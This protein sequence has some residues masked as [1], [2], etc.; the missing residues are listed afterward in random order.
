MGLT[1]F[2]LARRRAEEAQAAEEA[3]EVVD[4]ESPELEESEA[5]NPDREALAKEALALG[6]EFKGKPAP[7]SVLKKWSFDRLAEAIKERRAFLAN[8]PQAEVEEPEG[9]PGEDGEGESDPVPEAG[10]QT[11]EAQAAEEAAEAQN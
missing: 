11:N 1:G 10:G 6:V 8:P 2:N 7:I 4:D 3:A 5:Q 9:A